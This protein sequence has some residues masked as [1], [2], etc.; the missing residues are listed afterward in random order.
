MTT[1]LQTMPCDTRRGDGGVWYQLRDERERI[2]ETLLGMPHVSQQADA[3][4]AEVLQLQTRLRFIDDAL[5]RVTAGSYGDCVS[6]GRW[7]EDTQL[8]DDAALP[9]CCAC[10]QRSSTPAPF[11]R[12]FPYELETISSAIRGLL[13]T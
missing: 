5:D 12:H 7:I 6:C 9:F 4:K 3:M 11:L 1:N 2:C 8:H 13:R 10:Q